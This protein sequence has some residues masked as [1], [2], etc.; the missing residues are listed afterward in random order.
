[1]G[2]DGHGDAGCVWGDVWRKDTCEY[3]EVK[4]TY[5]WSLELTASSHPTLQT[6]A[7]VTDAAH[8]WYPIGEEE[9]GDRI[10]QL[11]GEQ[12]AHASQGGRGDT[13]GS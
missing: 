10:K 2:G 9:S 8:R 11:G 5:S 12:P 4:P 1:M 6:Q 13:R 3:P 7:S